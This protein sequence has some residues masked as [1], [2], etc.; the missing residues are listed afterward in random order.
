MKSLTDMRLS[1]AEKQK[2]YATKLGRL[3]RVMA[4]GNAYTS[5]QLATVL[6]TNDGTDAT[7]H[8]IALSSLIKWGNSTGAHHFQ[9]AGMHMGTKFG[10]TILMVLPPECGSE[11]D[12]DNSSACRACI[13]GWST[14]N[15]DGTISAVLTQD[16]SSSSTVGSQEPEGEHHEALQEQ[17][18]PGRASALLWC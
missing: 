14:L 7:T 15:P 6:A 13:R 2:G 8:T 16:D 17:N 5:A 3:V 11:A 4:H 18:E 10:R 9:Q 1:S 12:N